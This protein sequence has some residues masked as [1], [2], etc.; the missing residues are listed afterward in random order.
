MM[1]VRLTHSFLEAHGFNE[2]RSDHL[3]GRAVPGTKGPQVA[4]LTAVGIG[5]DP[6]PM[7]IIEPCGMFWQSNLHV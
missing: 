1:R 6:G 7:Q 3:A 5:G 4:L 2:A